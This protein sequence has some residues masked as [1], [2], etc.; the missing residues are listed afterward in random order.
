MDTLVLDNFRCFPGR[1][2]VSL[3]PITLLVGENSS[4]KTSFLAGARTAY[5]LF[6]EWSLNDFNA[7]PFKMG[8][9]DDI[10]NSNDKRSFFSVGLKTEQEVNSTL[11]EIESTFKNQKNQASIGNLLYTIRKNNEI[12][13]AIEIDI[14][15][16]T[17]EITTSDGTFTS[18]A[19]V[20]SYSL[21]PIPYLFNSVLI[22]EL[23]NKVDFLNLLDK[24]FLK[25]KTRPDVYCPAPIRAEP[26]RFYE[27]H[28]GQ[29]EPYGSHVPS[30]INEL[31]GTAA[32]IRLRSYLAEFAQSA[33]L[34]RKI[35]AE[36]IG[37]ESAPLFQLTAEVN[38]TK[39]NI[40]DIGYGVSQVL[41]IAVEAI[42]GPKGRVHL[43][44]QPEVHLHPRA[45]AELGS[46][47]GKLASTDQKTFLIETHS[48]YLINRI[49]MDIRDD[50]HIQ[51]TD[52]VILYFELNQSGANI[53]PIYI[54]KEG[55]LIDPPPSY[56]QFFLQE[57]SRFLGV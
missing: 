15:R 7:P 18:E 44:Q 27:A 38:G 26:Q 14:E 6:T 25:N 35:Q 47:F 39:R 10:I 21:P 12:K 46:L 31:A 53:H 42:Q 13:S 43:L 4:G 30:V 2:E 54:D 17:I 49:C 20:P 19:R 56:R 29:P 16:K 34:F 3:R 51:H 24:T 22:S 40:A 5:N 37:T 41:P 45:Q 57:E 50:K 36:K 52:A 33:G 9:F 8:S 32:E 11:L 1:H 55:C 48:D 23:E 28:R